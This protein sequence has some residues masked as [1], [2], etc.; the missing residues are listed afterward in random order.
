[1]S[2]RDKAASALSSKDSERD[3]KF[4]VQVVKLERDVAAVNAK[5]ADANRL[6]ETEKTA[7]ATCESQASKAVAK[8]NE[9]Q[10]KQSGVIAA[11]DKVS[12]IQARRG[13]A[14]P[15]AGVHEPCPGE[16]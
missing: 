14:R 11:S 12:R 5:L 8:L 3:D 9:F 4:R 7:R 1:M 2:R 15:C 13:V 10:A 6:L 16:R